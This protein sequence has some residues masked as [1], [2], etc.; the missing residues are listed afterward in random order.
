M[1]QNAE[2]SK[3]YAIFVQLTFISIANECSFFFIFAE[4]LQNS[5]SK[6]TDKQTMNEP[7]QFQIENSMPESGCV[8]I[9]VLSMPALNE[10]KLRTDVRKK[11]Q[12]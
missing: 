8:C 10:K 1:L 3:R 2:I 5:E 11:K 4:C 7:D 9:Q 12:K 6:Q